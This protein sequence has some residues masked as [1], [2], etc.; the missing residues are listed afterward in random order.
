MLYSTPHTSPNIHHLHHPLLLL[1]HLL[2]SPL[3][4]PLSS[5]FSPTLSPILC[6][7]PLVVLEDGQ[8][9][10]LLPL[11]GLGLN[12]GQKGAEVGLVLLGLG[13]VGAREDLLLQRELGGAAQAEDAVVA[14]AGREALQ[15]LLHVLVLLRDEVVGAARSGRLVSDGGERE[16]CPIGA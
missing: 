15:G 12:G 9:I 4:P 6:I 5:A 2:L 8:R 13:P 16:G 10:E 11:A 1:L 3:L 7:T 14:L